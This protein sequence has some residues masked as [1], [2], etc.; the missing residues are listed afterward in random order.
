[1]KQNK[2]T[3]N[4]IGPDTSTLYVFKHLYFMNNM[5]ATMLFFRSFFF[6]K[7]LIPRYVSEITSWARAII[8][9]KK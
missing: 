2:R 3:N 4:F 6:N 9:L 7:I 1:M 5:I 8:I